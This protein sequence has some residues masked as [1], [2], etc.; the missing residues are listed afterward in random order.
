MTYAQLL[1]ALMAPIF[2]HSRQND[3]LPF[4]PLLVCTVFQEDQANLR[5]TSQQ[6]AS[7]GKPPTALLYLPQS[8]AGIGLSKVSDLA[9]IRKWEWF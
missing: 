7:P 5:R 8:M 6:N 3:S 9:Q 2:R 4:A 1:E